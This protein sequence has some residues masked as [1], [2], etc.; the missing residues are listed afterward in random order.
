MMR[1]I[2]STK[3]NKFPPAITEYV[4]FMIPSPVGWDSALPL[5][6]PWLLWYSQTP[7]PSWRQPRAAR[8]ERTSSDRHG[9]RGHASPGAWTPLGSPDS[10]RARPRRLGQWHAVGGARSDVLAMGR[11][12]RPA[13]KKCLLLWDHRAPRYDPTS[14]KVRFQ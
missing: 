6:P 11:I 8:S 7:P 5:R 3:W 14:A 10:E 2:T 1:Q 13:W 9:Q 12:T 4:V